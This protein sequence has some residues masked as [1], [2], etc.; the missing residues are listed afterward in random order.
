MAPQDE[1]AVE[2]EQEVLAHRF[3]LLEPAAVEPRSEPFHRRSRMRRLDLDALADEDLQPTG[4]TV[5]RISF[6]H[7]RKPTIE[8]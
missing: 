7:A 5:E 3:H 8:S 4:R 6:R 1:A 2:V